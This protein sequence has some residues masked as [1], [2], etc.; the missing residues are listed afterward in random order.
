V[1]GVRA[2]LDLAAA[3][4]RGVIVDLALP[5]GRADPDP[6][7]V[8]VLLLTHELLRADAVPEDPIATA[9]GAAA[10]LPFLD[11]RDVVVASPALTPI[12]R[13]LDGD[14]ATGTGA[15]FVVAGGRV[16]VLT[17]RL[18]VLQAFTVYEP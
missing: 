4:P 18:G 1:D 10:F 9:A 5:P 2:G 17:D 11:G 16:R 15:R 8:R 14:F 13:D 3:S 6:A 12:P 7:D